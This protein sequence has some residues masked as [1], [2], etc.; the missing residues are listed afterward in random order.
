MTTAVLTLINIVFAGL[1]AGEEFAICYGIRVP[2]A[3]LDRQ[4]NIQLRQALIRRLRVFVPILFGLALLSGVAVTVHAGW[5]LKFSLR[6]GGLFAL[7][8]FI[9]VTLVG[10]VPINKAALTWNSADPPQDWQL[11]IKTWEKLDTWRTWSAIAAF[12]LFLAAVITG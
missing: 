6:C 10:T 3:S 8:T 1:L 9:T 12:L 11:V 7:L 2:M 5:D 4:P